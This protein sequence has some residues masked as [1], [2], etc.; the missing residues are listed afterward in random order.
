MQPDICKDYKE[1]GFCGYGDSCKFLH[2]RSDYKSGWQLEKE[3]DNEQAIKKKKLEQTISNFQ[4]NEENDNT[5]TGPGED[6]D[7]DED[8]NKY[9]IDNEEEELPFAC[10]ICREDFKNPIMTLCNHYF[11]LQC[12]IDSGKK[13][14]NKCIVCNKQT[15]GVFNRP[16]KLL[17]KIAATKGDDFSSSG[18]NFKPIISTVV[19]RGTWETVEN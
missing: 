10:F 16:N 3:W 11:C 5:I 8:D 7:D 6:N 1:T 9:V 19:K 4:K 12:A 14:N 18:M 2:D 13:N 17:K 15:Y